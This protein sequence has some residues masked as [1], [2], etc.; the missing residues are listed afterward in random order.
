MPLALILVGA[1]FLVAAVRDT[2]KDLGDLLK[3]M[4]TGPGSFTAWA[5]GFLVVALLG[6]SDTLRPLSRALMGLLLLVLI[7]TP[8]NADL[9]SSLRSQLLGEKNTALPPQ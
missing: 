6:V 9:F 5:I 7:L 2:T 4:F 8:A 3:E 1:V